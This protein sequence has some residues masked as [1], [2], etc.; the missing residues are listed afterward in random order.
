MPIAV[1]CRVWTT[2]EVAGLIWGI[3]KASE[4]QIRDGQVTVWLYDSGVRYMAEPLGSEVWQTFKETLELRHGDCE[5]LVAA[6][7]AELRVRKG[8]MAEPYVK[9]VRP[10]LRHCL[11]RLPS[12]ALECP[13]R[14]LGM[15][16]GKVG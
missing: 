10:G 6:R 2:A 4:A 7:C 3:M 9:D 8:I 1:T 11:V 15:G 13:S 12:G 14:T 16:K 5:D